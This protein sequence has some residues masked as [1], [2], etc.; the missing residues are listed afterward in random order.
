VKPQSVVSASSTRA[1]VREA[2]RW[3]RGR[4]WGPKWM[5]IG[6]GT[7]LLLPMLAMACIRPRL[8]PRRWLTRCGADGFSTQ[9]RRLPDEISGKQ[10]SRPD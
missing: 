4:A 8:A 10:R 3:V 5:R 7:S 1:A 2:R 9:Q 6:R